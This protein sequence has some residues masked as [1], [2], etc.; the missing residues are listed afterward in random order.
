MNSF[1]MFIQVCGFNRARQRDKLVRLIGDFANLQDEAERVDS[2]L[3]EI[4]PDECDRR[5]Y[6]ST[7]VLYHCLRAMSMYI[8]SGLE[9]E[10]YSLH[11]YLYIFWYLSDYLY[12]WIIS[13]LKRAECLA[14]QVKSINAKSKKPKPKKKSMKLYC[15]EI[16]FSQSLKCMFCGYYSVS[17]FNV[18]RLT[19]LFLVVFI[20]CCFYS[21]LQAL[22]GFLKD[23]RIPQPLSKFDN[24]QIRFEHRFAPFSALMTPP[25]VSYH[26]FKDYRE[27]TLKNTSTSLYA[28]A[29]NYF[30]Q[31]R[32]ILESISSADSEVTFKFELNF[33]V[34][35][36][37]MKLILWS[38]SG[39]WHYPNCQSELC[40]YEFT[41]QWSQKGLKNNTQIRFHNSQISTN[42]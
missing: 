9:L 15:R 5:P 23:S 25:P 38:F 31:A 12:N 14:D 29:S 35:K 13:T 39:R 32:T 10:L 16:M 33:N 27:Y 42:Y 18:R 8:L 7:W 22:A 41:C 19:L 40:C 37:L 1:V 21:L 28:D 17:V 24:E 11:E 20:L 34:H 2:Y 36:I 4:N 26:Q 6:F 30:H 3:H